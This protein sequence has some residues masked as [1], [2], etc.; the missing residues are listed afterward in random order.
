[1]L[2]GKEKELFCEILG[3]VNLQDLI[4]LTDTVTNR[5]I[6]TENREE[7]IEAILLF[8]KNANHLL[9]RKKIKREILYQYLAE[10]GFV[11]PTTADKSFLCRKILNICGSTQNNLPQEI[12]PHTGNQQGTMAIGAVSTNQPVDG[13]QLAEQFA[14]WFYQLLNATCEN[15]ALAGSQSDNQWGPQHFWADSKCRIT[16]L[17]HQHITDECEGANAVSTK[18]IEVLSTE[19]LF[20]NANT[21]GVKG[22]VDAYGLARVMVAGT[23]HRAQ[24]CLGIFEQSFGIVRDPQMDNNWKIKFTEL[25]LKAQHQIGGSGEAAAALMAPHGG[26]VVTYK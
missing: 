20:L 18:L 21:L 14:S 6:S 1:M 15:G 25:K 24:E 3:R 16:M 7:A 11:A 2:T 17:S 8:S 10:K 4:S 19:K 26:Q 23:V 9:R 22:M 13:Q 12:E 5:V